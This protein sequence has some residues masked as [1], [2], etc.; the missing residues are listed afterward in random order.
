MTSRFEISVFA[1]EGLTFNKHPAGTAKI[2]APSHNIKW[3]ARL[4]PSRVECSV[5]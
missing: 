2:N 3:N 1:D 5:Y 4:L